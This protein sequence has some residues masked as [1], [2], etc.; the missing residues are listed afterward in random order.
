MFSSFSCTKF[1]QEDPKSYIT[2]TNFFKTTN[3]VIA[4]ANGIYQAARYE[5][6]SGVPPIYLTE[7]LS[8]DGAL[9]GTAVG[10]RLELD[11]LRYTS[12]DVTMASVWASSYTVINRANTVIF[13][14]DST[15][16]PNA[17]TICRR[18]IAEAKFWRAYTYFRLVRL[19]GDVPLVSTPSVNGEIYP[20]RSN[21][22]LVYNQII[23]DLKYAE[24]N[25]DPYYGY[26]DALN[27]GRA[28]AVAAKALLGKVYLTMSG[29]PLKDSSKIQMASDKFNEIIT[30]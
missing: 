16:F 24:Q 12:Q 25:L 8:D 23:E 28:T 2:P 15:A 9:G 19:W 3:E 10:E 27:G 18:V 17:G 26:N 1:L 20:A 5:V 14:I 7:I 13:Y 21:S 4:A 30:N 29:Y 6:A 11:Q 22:T